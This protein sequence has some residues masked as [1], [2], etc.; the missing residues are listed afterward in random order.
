MPTVFIMGESPVIGLE[1]M[2]CGLAA[3][4]NVC[5]LACAADRISASDP[6]LKQMSSDA[7]DP[8]PVARALSGVDD[9]VQTLSLRPSPEMICKPIRRRYRS[10]ASSP[11][12]YRGAPRQS[13]HRGF[14]DAYLIGA[15]G[16]PIG[17]LHTTAA[18]MA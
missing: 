6:G 13:S 14:A 16:P 1:T 9:V 8:E 5:A 4:H 11:Q 3:R 18:A 10:D 2:K 12:S 17:C 15:C 7:L